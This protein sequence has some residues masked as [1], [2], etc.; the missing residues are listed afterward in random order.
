MEDKNFTSFERQIE[1]LK[2]RKL[3]IVDEESALRSLRKYGYYNIINGYKDPYVESNASGESYKAGV[4]FEQIYALYTLDRNLRNIVMDAMLEVEDTLKTATAHI[5]AE[6]FSADQR[7]YLKRTNYRTGKPINDSG[8]YTIDPLFRKFHKIMNDNTHPVKHYRE[9]YHNV[10]PWIL[11]K[12]ASFGNIVN[13][14]KLQKG[15]QKRKIIS[16]VYNVPVSLVSANQDLYNLFMDTLFVCLDFRNRAAHGGRIYNF[17]SKSE[18]RYNRILHNTLS[19][20]PALYR[21]GRG[22]TGL[23]TLYVSLNFFDNPA[24]QIKLKT[25]IDFY[26][27]RYLEKFPSEQEYLSKFLDLEI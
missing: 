1:I 16:L 5:I 8:D 17:Q 6:A 10:P 27:N 18:F 9:T 24:P 3:T 7:E 13:F 19:I 14:I 22:H 26:V 15:P 11:L 25:G 21:Q 12:E 20:S 23:P 2:S 4:T